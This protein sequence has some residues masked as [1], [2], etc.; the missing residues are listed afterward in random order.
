M[1]PV[2]LIAML[3]ALVFPIALL[4]EA[5]SIEG[6][7]YNAEKTSKILLY[8]TTAGTIAGKIC[9]LKE[10]NENGKPKVDNKNP[11]KALRSRPEMNLVV[12]QGLVSK[13]KNKWDSGTIYDPKS[14]NTY[15]SKAELIGPN[16]L[17]LRGF[18]GISLVGRTEVWTRAND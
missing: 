12:V 10:P 18:I 4:A 15:S 14:G 6:T 13:G 3:F 8:K 7:W 11:D 5:Y 16:T 2:I 9:W 1:K 17:K